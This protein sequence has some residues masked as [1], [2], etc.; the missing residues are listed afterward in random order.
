MVST[1]DKFKHE[2]NRTYFLSIFFIIKHFYLWYW[3]SAKSQMGRIW[4]IYFL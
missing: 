2:E 1:L 3:Y 4:G